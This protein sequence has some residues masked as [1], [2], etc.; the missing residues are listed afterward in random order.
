MIFN[1]IFFPGKDLSSTEAA[2]KN[3]LTGTSYLFSDLIKVC[4]DESKDQ[5]NV[6][7][8]PLSSSGNASDTT[9][10]FNGLNN[11]SSG[12][13]NSINSVDCTDLKIF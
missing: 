5:L 6:K 11:V 13:Q 10:L 2:T 7:Q 1:S 12:D 9:G 3:K 8:I 4:I